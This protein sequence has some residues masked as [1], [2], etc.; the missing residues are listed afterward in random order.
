MRQLRPEGMVSSMLYRTQILVALCVSVLVA[1]RG[2]I[3]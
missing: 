3:I 1:R 2:A